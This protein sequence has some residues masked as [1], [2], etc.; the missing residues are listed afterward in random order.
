E[1]RKW[2]ER[3]VRAVNAVFPPDPQEVT[4]WHTCQRYLEQVQACDTLMQKHQLLLPEAAELLDRAG[5]YLRERGLYFLAEPLYRR[6]LS[7]REQLMGEAHLTSVLSMIQLA[8]LYFRQ[9]EYT[10]AE[11]LYQ[12]ALPIVEQQIGAEH[13]LIVDVLSGLARVYGNQGKYAQA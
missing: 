8:S 11:A 6:A 7:M 13:P 3:L 1:Q 9:D 10:A 4:S 12:R 5:T 2:A